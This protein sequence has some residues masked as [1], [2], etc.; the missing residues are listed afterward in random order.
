[1]S[2]RK[3]IADELRALADL[4]EREGWS[5]LW[6]DAVKDLVTDAWKEQDDSP[7]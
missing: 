7:A 2:E 6:D 1:M 3:K 4:V 5:F